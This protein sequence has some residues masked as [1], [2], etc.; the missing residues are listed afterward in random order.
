[1]VQCS[2]LARDVQNGVGAASGFLVQALEGFRRGQNDQFD[3]SFVSFT[4][5]IVHDGKGAVESV[6][7][8]QLPK[9]QGIIG[10]TAE[11]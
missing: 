2:G 1:M 8:D 10:A 3:S 11:G 4:L 9:R 5:H 7:N 6:A